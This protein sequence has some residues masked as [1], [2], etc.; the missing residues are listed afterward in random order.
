MTQPP[1]FT[2]GAA[3]GRLPLLGHALPLR[4]RPLE[5]LAALPALGDLVTVHFG[6]TPARVACHPELV[7]QILRDPQT[8]DKGG[9]VFDRA[10]VLLGNGLVTCNREEHRVQRRLLQ[11]AF[12]SARLAGYAAAVGAETERAIAGWR[13]GTVVE[14]DTL[15]HVLTA[16]VTART[17]FATE[18]ADGLVDE[19]AYCL[20]V[21]VSG[22]YQRMTVPLGLLERL[23]TPGNRR[24]QRALDRLGVIIDSLI[25][26]YRHSPQDRGDL[27]SALLAVR[28]EE[29]G[30]GLSGGEVH[31]QVMTVLSA[32]TETTANAIA[33]AFHLLAANPTPE[34]RLHAE[35]DR[36]LAGRPP[37]PGDLPELRYTRQVV[38]ES[39]RLMPPVWLLTRVTTADA[40]LGGHRLPAG[41]TV[42]FSPYSLHRDP[43][44]FADPDSFDPDRWQPERQTE[45]PRGAMVPFGAGARKCIG[46]VFALNEAVLV[47]AGMAG[48]WRLR[49]VT[50]RQVRPEPRMTLGTGALPMLPEPR[51]AGAVV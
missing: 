39:L 14:L 41:S 11:P 29:S 7:R 50:D 12:H 24:F 35:L 30:A 2:T 18:L 28:D 38:T 40:V 9:P 10:R 44:L 33:W 27:I 49:P 32:G 16:R 20:G 46:D 13:P 25:E 5:F 31:D 34:R 37:V 21:L 36:V 8:Y 23:P 3:P 43:A 17:L 19:V 6:P 15:L 26:E 42:A 4:R 51:R 1:A 22:M 45:V 48:R 47:L